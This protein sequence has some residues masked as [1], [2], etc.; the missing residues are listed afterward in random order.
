MNKELTSVVINGGL[1]ESKFKYL[2]DQFSTFF[3]QAKEFEAKAR[4]INVTDESQKD[5]MMVA[6]KI[7]LTIQ[8]IRSDTEKTRKKLKEQSLREG[9]A[10]DGVANVIKALIVPI[11]EHLEKQ[12]KFIQNIEIERKRKLV[13][14]RTSLLGAYVEDM[15][16]Y[17]LS[18]MTNEAFDNLIASSKLA[19][20]A[21]EKAEQK[22][23]ED[24]IAA[25]KKAKEEAAELKTEN[26][27][28]KAAAAEKEKEDKAKRLEQEKID[29]EKKADAQKERDK[30]VEAQKKIDDEKAIIAQRQKD[31]EAADQKILD[32]KAAEEKAARLAPEKDK[33]RAFAASIKSIAGPK[34][35]SV[36]GQ[37]IVS[38]AEKSM[39]NISQEIENQIK[40]LF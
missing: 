29:T 9:K 13:E 23:E 35:L 21:Q 33:L 18:E 26:D 2:L 22:A 15:S 31:K 30:I 36:G 40:R 28:L 5:E 32:D 24:R 3:E 1:E 14:N 25:E 17:N 39:L 6:R 12:E 27:K 16:A 34:G 19:R 10:I 4:E 38:G 37:K 20:E 7:R 8:K 11:E